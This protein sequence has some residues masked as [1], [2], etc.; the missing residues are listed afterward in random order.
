MS[1]IW[2][3]CS[4][5]SSINVVQ[6]D[7]EE[8]NAVSGMDG[9]PVGEDVWIPHSA[10]LDGCGVATL[11]FGCQTTSN[12]EECFFD[13]IQFRSGGNVQVSL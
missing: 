8:D 4:D 9:L 5:G 6:G 10:A 3:E 11:T 13:H 2:V 12:S 7:L 1:R